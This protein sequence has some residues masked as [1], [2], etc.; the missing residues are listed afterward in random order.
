[1]TDAVDI[2]QYNDFRAFMKDAYKSRKRL[3]GK[4]SHR[5]I[6]LKIG[7]KSAG[8]FADVVAGRMGLNPQHVQPL[9]ALFNLKTSGRDFF[10]LLVELD[11]SESVGARTRALKS[12]MSFKGVKPEVVGNDQ[13]EFYG[14]WFH[15]ALRELLILLP[16][17]NDHETLA[18]MLEPHVMPKQIKKSLL[19]MARLG[20]IKETPSGRL[21]PTSTNLIKDKSASQVQW[22]MIQK[23]F[24]ELSLTALERY[25]KEERDFSALTLTFSPE[26]LRKAGEEI[27]CLRKRLLTL[28][29]KDQG[30]NRVYQCNFNVYPLTKTIEV[31][32]G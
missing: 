21:K 14:A 2:F 30:S 7:V 22:V 16:S 28:S 24:I 27:A 4:F 25:K 23:A 13:F 5:F 32:N 11:Q 10:R 9:S 12:I 19:L 26:G 20:L 1:M 8:W 3:D 6:Q 18:R 17:K 29:E 31:K 15:S